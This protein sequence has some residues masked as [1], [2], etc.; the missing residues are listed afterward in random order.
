MNMKNSLRNTYGTAFLC[1]IISLVVYLQTMLPGVG[2]YGDTSKFQFI[3]KT[4]GLPHPSGF[5]TYIFISALFARLPWGTLA[6]RINFMSVL[7]GALTVGTLCLI[8]ARLTKNLFAAAVSSLIFA[9]SFT[10][11]STCLI[12]EV[13]TLTFFFIAATVWCLIRWRETMRRSWFYLACLLYA[14]SFGNH[15]MVIILIP[16]FLFIVI[17]TDRGIF[18]SGRAIAAIVLIVALGASQYIF[19]LLRSLQ[20]PIYCEGAVRDIRELIW[21]ATGGTFK[22]HYFEFS[23]RQ[24]VTIS[25][26]VYLRLL[27]N[28]LTLPGALLAGAGFI[29]F[30]RKRRVWSLFFLIFYFTTVGLYINGPH[31]EQPIYFVPATMCLAIAIAFV[32]TVGRERERGRTLV[33]AIALVILANRLYGSYSVEDL[34]RKRE[35]DETAES[36][37][38]AVKPESIILSPNYHWTEALLY[39]ILGE[40]KRA[41]DRVYVLHHWTPGGLDDYRAGRVPTWDPYRPRGPIPERFNLYLFALEKEP[42]LLK[43]IRAAG[44]EALPVIQKEPPLMAELRSLDEDM[45]MLVAVKDEGTTI[46]SDEGYDVVNALGLRTLAVRGNTFGWAAADAVVRCQG[47]WRGWQHFRYSPVEI[48]TAAGEPIIKTPYV[49]PAA[50]EINCAGYGRGDRNE[51]SVAGQKVTKSKHGLN[52][53]LIDRASGLVERTINV[54]PSGLGRLRPVYLYELIPS[55]SD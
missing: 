11:W 40:E 54:P 42:R 52:I 17:A 26:P 23:P 45:I 35:Y 3:G 46:L 48:K 41:G 8:S 7:F 37:L 1:G 53:V 16:P 33:T 21:F 15:L 51:I 50:I 43:K 34:S 10:F 22:R 44:W 2:G 18:R 28:Q 47:R 20:Q 19:L 5:P 13:Y 55:K 6:W 14:L 12:A 36:V 27:V 25:I 39:K 49:Y 4:L 38:A 30:F 9:F 32:L 29:Q 31:I 24:V